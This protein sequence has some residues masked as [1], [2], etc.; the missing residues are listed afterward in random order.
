MDVHLLLLFFAAQILL[1]LTPGPD[2]LYVMS[3]GVAGGRRSALISVGGICSGYLADSVLA[4]LGLA[5]LLQSSDVVFEI[6][7]YAGAAYL[8][9]L[10][11]GM[12]LGKGV[13]LEAGEHTDVGEDGEPGWAVFR[14]GFLTAVLN[15][16]G[17]LLFLSLLPQFVTPSAAFPIGIQLL[18]LGLVHTVNCAVIY[19]AVGI[20]SARLGE[21]LKRRLG[22]ARMIRWLAGSVLSALG[23]RLVFPGNR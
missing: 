5:A 2:W 20:G 17:L 8:F 15:P 21:I 14:Q 19:S 12:I 23:L 9:Y 1:A 16:K 22:L 10:G 6:V 4:A 13:G 3:R 7:R 18:V 11:V